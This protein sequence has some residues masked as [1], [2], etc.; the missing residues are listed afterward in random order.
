MSVAQVEQPKK[1]RKPAVRRAALGPH[2]RQHRLLE[3]IDWRTREGQVLIAARADCSCR[4]QPQQRAEG[5]DREG[6]RAPALHRADGPRGAGGWDDDRAQQQGAYPL[7]YSRRWNF[8]RPRGRLASCV[9][10]PVVWRCLRRA[11]SLRIGSAGA[12][13]H[14]ALCGRNGVFANS[15]E[16]RRETL[17]FASLSCEADRG[18]SVGPTGASA[19]AS[20]SGGNSS[21]KPATEVSFAGRG[22]P[23]SLYKRGG[24]ARAA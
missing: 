9:R 2:T 14:F 23:A 3:G 4:R 1:R 18:C 5:A 22:S 20:S 7:T 8:S 15:D 16:P 21:A 6:E 19:L 11:A 17:R 12:G 10:L 13:A 24:V